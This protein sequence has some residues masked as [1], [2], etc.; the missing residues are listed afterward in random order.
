MAGRLTLIKAV[1]ASSLNHSFM[2]YKWPLNLI[3]KLVDAAMR[4]FLWTGY[5]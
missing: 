5:V 2:I 1:I 4:N 3:R